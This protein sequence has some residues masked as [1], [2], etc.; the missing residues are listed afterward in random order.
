MRA[1]CFS[2]DGAFGLSAAAGDRHVAV[3]DL[4]AAGAEGGVAAAAALLA[5]EEP[6]V[7]VSAAA[8]PGAADVTLVALAQSG[9]AYVWRGQGVLGA[10]A[11]PP[12]R[13]R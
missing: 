7:S 2:P 1:L 8:G 10:A 6:A 9:D 3:W 5:L 4:G 12:T 11:A 13:I